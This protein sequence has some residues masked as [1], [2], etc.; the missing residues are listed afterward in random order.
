MATS[1]TMNLQ[2]GGNGEEIVNGIT[3]GIGALLSIAG[4]VLLVVC[5][6]LYGDGWHIVS[7]SIF[8]STLVILYGVSTLYHSFSK[9]SV[10]LFFKKLDH[11]AIF[12]LIAGTYTPFM[13]V[14]LRGAWGWSVFGIIWA[15][16]AIGIFIKSI[17]VLSF[18]RLSVVVYVCMGWLI[19]IAIKE[20]LNEVPSSSFIFLLIGGICYTAGVI[21]YAWRK[22]PFN[23]G[24]WHIFV[25][26]GSILHYFA[27]L[28][29]LRQG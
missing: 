27:V 7:F 23:H 2:R 9:P 11:C 6:A 17:N 28:C 10:K 19:L 24:V 25:L 22:M 13:L 16:A 20:V 14:S 21:F 4:L 3:H 18:K 29:I 8:G 26:S 5:A 1:Q 15:L 12:L